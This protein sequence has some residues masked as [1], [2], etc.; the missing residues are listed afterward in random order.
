M[1]VS[2]SQ[3]ERRLAE[4]LPAER[5][6][7]EPRVLQSN[8]EDYAWFSNLLDEALADCRA[9]VVAWPEDE[10]E[11]AGV[12]AAAY[13]TRTPV[14][15]RGGGTGNYGQCVP[16]LGGLVVNMGRMSRVLE[17]GDGFAR[18]QAGV[19]LVTLDRAAHPSGQEIRIY[20]STYLTATVVGFVCGG[21]GGIGSVTHGFLADG[22]VL[23]ANVF[24]VTERPTPRTVA[25]E[26]LD[27]FIHTYGTTGVL[28]DVTVPLAPRLEWEQAV[29]SFPD[30]FSCHEF[31]LALVRDR[32]IDKRLVSTVEPAVA[33][34]FSR[35]RVPFRTDRT[36][37]LLMFGSGQG[38]T[39]ATLAGHHGGEVDISLPADSKTRLSDFTWNHTTAWAKKA[40]P[41][42]TYLQM[43]FTIERFEEQVGA[44]RAEY[45]DDV[46]IHGEYTRTGGGLSL[47]SLPI[48][49][50]RGAAYLDRM[51]A[52]LEGIGIFIANPHT[53]VLEEGTQVE[54]LPALLET[55]R[56]NDPAGLLNPGK[57]GTERR[58]ALPLSRRTSTLGLGTSRRPLTDLDV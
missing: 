42:L 29:V 18:V 6:S 49:P 37:A 58:R 1:V 7:T 16:L 36:S 45:G 30:L 8:S 32:S 41:N 26:G 14:T 24:P 5:I 47:A 33:R 51:I 52:F 9:E 20:P 17:L 43:A 27:R 12:L 35:A 28:A 53:Y 3:L 54:N 2:V 44:I 50:Y 31:C 25:G 46:A 34:Y 57:V 56:Q 48:I 15:I 19:K 21:S 38:A 39:V 10:A 11:L 13:E 55:K 23:A 4:I 40:D 22:N